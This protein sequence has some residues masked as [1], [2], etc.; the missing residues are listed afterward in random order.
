MASNLSNL[1]IF[2]IRVFPPKTE[3]QSICGVFKTLAQD[4][5]L[6]DQTL[7]CV[8]KDKP[9]IHI[10]GMHICIH[11][12]K[13]F[14]PLQFPPLCKLPICINSPS[15]PGYSPPS[16]PLVFFLCIWQG[17]GKKKKISNTTPINLPTTSPQLHRL[18]SLQNNQ[19]PI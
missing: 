2:R 6:R 1:K 14:L 12:I 7:S 11:H 18:P 13:L 16:L 3:Y 9:F 4:I 8:T 19:S 10:G 17:G 5:I 15:Q